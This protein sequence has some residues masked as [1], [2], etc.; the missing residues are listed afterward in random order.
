MKEERKR[1]LGGHAES[2]LKSGCVLPRV[3]VSI[4]AIVCGSFGS[5]EFLGTILSERDVVVPSSA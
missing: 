5:C 4:R 2:W 1:K 3:D